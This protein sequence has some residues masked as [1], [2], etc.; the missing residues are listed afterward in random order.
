M[1]NEEAMIHRA[2][3]AADEMCVRLRSDGEVSSHQ[4]VIV[5]DGSTDDT[6]RLADEL[7]S[8]DDHVTVVHHDRN[9]TLGRAVRSG[10][11][12]ATGDVV[13]VTGADLPFDLAETAKALRLM[14]LLDADV[15]APYRFDRTGEGPRRFVYSHAYNWLVRAVFGLRVRDVNF[16]AKLIRREV[17]DSIQLRSEGSFV[18][19]EL[20]AKATRQGFHVV[21]FGVDYFPR[22]RGVSTLSSWPVIVTILREMIAIGPEIRSSGVRRR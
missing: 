21:Q 8:I 18:D 19:V 5:D 10:I 20:L 11:E 12:A 4:I 6:P 3:A 22:S 9:R 2:V 7:A 16:A 14:E 17:L 1:W 13:L 15:V